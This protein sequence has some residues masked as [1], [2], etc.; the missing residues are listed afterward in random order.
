MNFSLIPLRVPEKKGLDRQTDGQ[1]SDP[2]RVPFLPFEV[3]KEGKRGGSD[4][5][6]EPDEKRRKKREFESGDRMKNEGATAPRPP[7]AARAPLGPNGHKGND[8][9][10]NSPDSLVTE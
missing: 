1:Q 4:R 10:F 5:H 3:K 9:C 7:A 6:I 2:T 8:M